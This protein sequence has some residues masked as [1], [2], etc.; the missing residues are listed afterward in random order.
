MVIIYQLSSHLP[1]EFF[2]LKA[3]PIHSRWEASYS[4]LLPISAGAFISRLSSLLKHLLP[5]RLDASNTAL[6]PLLTWACQI[7]STLITSFPSS[8]AYR[9][10][11]T[12]QKR[13][14]GQDN[15]WS[16][17]DLRTGLLVLSIH[18]RPPLPPCA[19]C[20]P[21]KLQDCRSKAFLWSG[22]C[23]S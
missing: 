11:S 9:T 23:P 5:A 8:E 20:Y 14:K 7:I 12:L 13:L 22:C 19:Q 16:T 10:Q 1:L 6:Q 2:W 17:T 15:T 4:C 21:L 18:T 3:P